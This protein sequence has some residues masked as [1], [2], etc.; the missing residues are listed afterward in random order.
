MAKAELKTRK[1]GKS[2][3]AFLDAIADE[4]RRKD[5]KTVLQM[6]KRA[7]NA[8]P[9]MWGENIVGFGSRPITYAN[10]TELDWPV[11]SFA[12][13]KNAVTLYILDSNPRQRALLKKLG[14]HTTGKCCLHIK[15]LSDVDLQ[16]LEELVRQ[17]AR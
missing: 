2:V 7:T 10:G 17:A 4:G 8:R 9:A 14:K 15:R 5:C 13:R 12:P 1:T 3:A 16:V 11:L 6:M